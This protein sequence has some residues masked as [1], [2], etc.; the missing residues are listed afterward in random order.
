MSN[1]NLSKSEITVLI[2]SLR[3][4]KEWQSLDVQRAERD[5]RDTR[6]MLEECEQLHDSEGFIKHWE[7]NL[8]QKL[9]HLAGTLQRQQYTEDLISR[10]TDAM[11]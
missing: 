6:H 10:L 2:D 9:I 5:V 4:S 8:R 3:A 1:L 7:V 11:D